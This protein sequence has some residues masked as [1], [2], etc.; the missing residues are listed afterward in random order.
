MLNRD[1]DRAVTRLA[2]RQHWAFHQ[3]QLRAIGGT[4]TMVND[5][6]D[7]GS[8]IRLTH[9]VFALAGRPPTWQRQYKAAE[10]CIPGAAIADRPA[11]LVHGLEGSKVLRPSLA[12]AHA[13]STRCAIADV[14]RASDLRTTEIGG[15]RVTTL[16]QTLVDVVPLLP[17]HASEAFFDDAL[18]SGRVTV[19]DLDER[20]ASRIAMRRPGGHDAAALV[21]D[22]RDTAWVELDSIL[23]LLT[24]RLLRALP[25][26]TTFVHQ[27]TMPWWG[28]GEGRVDIYIPAWGLIIELDGRR[29]HARVQAFDADR[30]RDNVAVANGH[31][32][33]RFTHAHLTLRP[34]E[35]I[36]IVLATG[37]SRLRLA[38]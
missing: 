9:N 33:L 5:R 37:E 30:W 20:A 27:A 38:S 15:I 3:R 10:L 11:L 19:E 6:V 17:I 22:R 29:W 28:P 34:D 21:D 35:V 23:E 24:S 2:Q 1:F 31:V 7:A 8:F 26:G 14:R 25:P 32:V 18:L 4:R 16:A 12:V 36:A 13:S